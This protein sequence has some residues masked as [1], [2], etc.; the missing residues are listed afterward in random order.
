MK[1]VDM[2]KELVHSATRAAALAGIALL[3]AWPVA[4]R[5]DDVPSYA[6]GP[7]P[8]TIAGTIY[9]INGRYV[10]TLE[11]VRGFED[12]VT[13]HDG[14]IITPTGVTLGSGQGAT[15]TGHTDGK[16]FDADEIDI[17]PQT[18]ANAQNVLP[19]TDY[20]SLVDG[21]QFPGYAFGY[22]ANAYGLAGYIGPYAQGYYGGSYYGG[23]YYGG[24]Y[25]GSGPSQSTPVNNPSGGA[26]TSP[27]AHRPVN[28]PPGSLPPGY[29]YPTGYRG[30][31]PIV[32]GSQ[33]QTYAS[34][35]QYRAAQPQY[36]AAPQGH[37]APAAA[38]ARS[39]R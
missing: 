30:V 31:G 24:G 20:Y 8:E 21:V 22:N 19:A 28:V 4:A 36:R 7:P 6:S 3:A 10:L 15:I 38:P 25:Y 27:I 18:I 12:S 9:A 34:A 32:R 35:P 39:S 14:T 33:P 2:R 16:T 29:R 1:H 5:S 26:G 11:D 23:G 37:S 17:D 13:L